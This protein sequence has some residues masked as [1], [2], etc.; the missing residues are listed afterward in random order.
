MYTDKLLATSYRP[1]NT[2]K[3]AQTRPHVRDALSMGFFIL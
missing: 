3:S 2:D 1:Q